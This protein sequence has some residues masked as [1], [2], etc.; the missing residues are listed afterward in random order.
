M[1]IPA[2]VTSA[3]SRF[4]Y[5]LLS[6]SKVKQQVADEKSALTSIK[7]FDIRRMIA[8]LHSRGLN[9]KS[10]ARV[11]SAWRGFFNYLIHHKNFTANPTQGL[12]APK[13]QKKLPQTLSTDQA[14]HFVSIEGDDFLSIRDRAILELFLFFWLT[15]IRAG[16]LNI[17]KLGLYR[18]HGH[19]HG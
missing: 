1:R 13:A 9:E 3:T 5:S 11:L 19:R 2:S 12:K 18:W 15:L 7:N 4:F 6:N 10:I 8:T 14:V 17:A 16:E